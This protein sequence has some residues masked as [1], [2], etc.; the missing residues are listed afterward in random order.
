MPIQLSERQQQTLAAALTV[1]ASAVLLCAVGLTFWLLSAFLIKF[2]SVFLPLAAAGVAALMLKPYYEWWE[3]RAPQA[4]ALT[5]VFLSLVLPLVL[6]VVV[7]VDQVAD[8]IARFPAWWTN[9]STWVEARWPRILELSQKYHVEERLQQVV[10]ERQDTLISGL[11]LL[12]DKAIS[13][14]AGAFSAVGSLLG[15]FIAPIYLAFFLLIDPRLT[16]G[17]AHVALPFLKPS[18]REDIAYLVGE[19]LSILVAFFRGQLLIALAQGILFAFGFGLAGL[20]LWLLIGLAM[21]FL[22]IIPYLGSLI[23]LGIALPLAF[24]QDSGGAWTLLWV[25][26]AFGAV[27]MIEGYVLTPKIMG[28]QTGLHPMAIMVGIFFW[29]TALNGI[30]GMLLA[31]PLTA[32]F[33]VFWRLAREKY[34]RELV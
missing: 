18:T 15:W 34:I 3:K 22:N 29:G 24:F 14:G 2:S 17:W 11:R 9:A 13:A 10:E 6:L 16:G 19:F 7:I 20:K 25:V 1:L 28:N 33:V 21:G 23:G 5:A 12:G 8:L 30:L 4:I 27:Q 31:I 32:F 26:V